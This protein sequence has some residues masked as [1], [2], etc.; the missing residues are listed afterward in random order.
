MLRLEKK[1]YTYLDPHYLVRLRKF[2]FEPGES[3][4]NIL[5]A[6]RYSYVR[7]IFLLIFLKV[8]SFVDK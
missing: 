7:T 2:N 5:E 3:W 4:F 1:K 6:I 8:K